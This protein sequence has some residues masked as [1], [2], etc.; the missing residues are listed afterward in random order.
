M[1]RLKQKKVEEKAAAEKA[2][3][4][5]KTAQIAPIANDEDKMDVDTSAN[6]AADEKSDESSGV[7][8]I[9][10][11][12][13]ASRADGAKKSKKR[14]PGEIRIQKGAIYVHR[15]LSCLSYLSYYT[16]K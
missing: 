6:E 7:K 2:V 1:I 4:E 3:E 12:G 5:A 13:K 10:I 9:G 8:L 14:T 15:M 16:F 11:G